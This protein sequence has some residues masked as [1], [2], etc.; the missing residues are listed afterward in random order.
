MSS[1]NDNGVKAQKVATTATPG[2]IGRAAA[3][4]DSVQDVGVNGMQQRAMQRL[5]A[6]KAAV[7]TTDAANTRVTVQRKHDAAGMTAALAIECI[8]AV[9]AASTAQTDD[10]D[11]LSESVAEQHEQVDV[12]SFDAE[13][14]AS[15][16]PCRKT[17][18]LRL[19][20][21]LV[22]CAVA[23]AA[24]VALPSATQLWPQ[25]Q[26]MRVCGARSDG[27]AADMH[28]VIDG[29]PLSGQLK[30]G[31]TGCDCGWRGV[32]THVAECLPALTTGVFAAWLP[33]AAHADIDALSLHAQRT[34]VKVATMKTGVFAE[35]LEEKL[36][37]TGDFVNGQAVRD[38]PGKGTRATRL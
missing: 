5:E 31:D 21:L 15:E 6:A 11:T 29:V 35:S 20:W 26:S 25:L 24:A 3:D 22:A 10:T 34:C 4:A 13:M 12:I 7:E 36:T 2:E 14:S 23:A 17:H 38:T 33:A 27:Y 37:S 19:L 30:V 1:Q 28:G 18:S 32:R 9:A 16:M 8:S